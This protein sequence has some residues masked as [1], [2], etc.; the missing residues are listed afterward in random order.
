[1]KE[2]LLIIFG[3][4]QQSDII[5]FYINKLQKKIHAYCVD[6]KFY[7]KIHLEIKK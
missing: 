5:S 2:K 4:G 1:M 6:E 7:K 3:T